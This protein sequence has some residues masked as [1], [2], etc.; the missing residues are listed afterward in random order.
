[1]FEDQDYV[2]ELKATMRFRGDPVLTSILA[3]M[4]TPGEDRTELRLTKDELQAL[5][6]TSVESGASLDGTEAWYMSAFAWA[7][8]CIAQWNRSTEAAKAAN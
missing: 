6:K 2:C 1:M 5:Q 8:V 4:R 7:Y 3:K